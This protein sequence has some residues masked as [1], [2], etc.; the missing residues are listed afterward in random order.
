MRRFDV[1]KQQEGET[2]A[3][4][5][6]N[7]RI[8]HREAWPKTDLKSTEADTLLCRKFVDGILDVELQKYLRLRDASDDCASTVSKARHFVDARELFRAPK[9]PAIR[10]TSLSVNYQTIVDGVIEALVLH[11]QG[12]TAEVHGLQARTSTANAGSKNKK[13]PLVSD[14]R[15]PVTHRREV[16][17]VLHQVVV[18]FV[19]RIRVLISQEA[20]R[21][22]LPVA[23]V[24]RATS[25]RNSET[26]MA[27][28]HGVIDT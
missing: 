26:I 21:M 28:G 3:V 10:T 2:L 13:N 4:F 27:P 25:R 5:E 14:H 18:R 23:V 11:D 1:R 7:L 19:S 24:C 16:P 9:K 20:S 12:H 17:V 15:H 6:Q 8:L 22:V